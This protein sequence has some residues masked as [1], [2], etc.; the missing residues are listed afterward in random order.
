MAR[1]RLYK[2]NDRSERGV[3]L[4]FWQRLSRTLKGTS[5]DRKEREDLE[6]VEHVIGM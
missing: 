5:K 1:P 2:A 3:A 4:G 6:D